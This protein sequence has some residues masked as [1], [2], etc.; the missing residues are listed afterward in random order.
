MSLFAEFVLSAVSPSQFPGDELPEIALAGRSNVGK[1][2]MINALLKQNKLARTS[3][4]PGRTQTLNFYRIWPE[5]KP[6]LGDP[7]APDHK[8]DRFTLKGSAREAA[9]ETNAFYFVD[10]PGYGYAK[11]SATQRAEWQ[12]LIENYLLQRPTLKAV[13][14][15]VDL[16]HPPSR[17]DVAMWDWLRHHGL[18]RLCL[19]TKADKIGKTQWSAHLKEVV[20]GLGLRSILTPG[21]DTPFDPDTEPVLVF[22]A[23]EGTGRDPL[24]SWVN[25][26]VRSDTKSL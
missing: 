6:K 24:W 25:A 13:I 8:T 22:S 11:V 20:Q 19:A 2:S 18:V 16:R 12:K 21:P 14:Q 9:H 1:S 23:E 17:E 3:N 26:A 10:M 15:I 5:G 7:K 4:T